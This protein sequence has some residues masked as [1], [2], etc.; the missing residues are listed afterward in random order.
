MDKVIFL[1]FIVK[2][3]KALLG[4]EDRLQFTAVE[5]T[6]ILEKCILFA[7]GEYGTV[8]IQ[9]HHVTVMSNFDIFYVIG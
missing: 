4:L 8:V 2:Y 7:G 6:N 3:C 9:Q 5:L 1:K